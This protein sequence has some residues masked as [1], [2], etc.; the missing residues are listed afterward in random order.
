MKKIIS[1]LVLTA[2]TSF[3]PRLTTA[4]ATTIGWTNGTHTRTKGVSVSGSSMQGMAIR[5][6]ES[7]AQ[8]LKGNSIATV[9]A[10]FCSS[11]YT[12]FTLFITDDLDGEYLYS[13][14]VSS[15]SS[16]KEYTLDTPYEISGEELYIGFVG[17]ISN[18]YSP[19]SFD[20]ST[21]YPE[22]SYVYNNG[23]WEDCYE[24][25]NGV[26]NIQLILSEDISF[27]DASLR[28]T[29]VDGFFRAGESIE[30]PCG[31]VFNFG[32]DTINTIEVSYKVADNE[33]QVT[34]FTDLGL[35]NGQTYD[36][37]LP[38]V[39]F[40]EAGTFDVEV[41][42]S[43]VNGM[44]YD[45]EPTDNSDSTS[46]TM[47][48]QD[49]KRMFLVEN[50]TTQQCTNCP[51]G[52]A[53]LQSAVGDRDDVCVVAHHSGY[54]TDAFTMTE[55]VALLFLEYTSS[56]GTFAPGFMTNRY[57]TD[58][59]SSTYASPGFFT[60]DPDD[61][62]DRLDELADMEPYVEVEIN[63]VY[64]EDT[65][66]LSG[67]VDVT[68]Y[69]TPPGGVVYINLYAVQDSIVASQT[70]GGD[71]YTHRHVFRGSIGTGNFGTP[72]TIAAGDVYSHEFSYT[73]PESITASYSSSYAETF[74]VD[75]SHMSLVAFASNYN[76]SDANDCI[77]YNAD[78]V[79]F[80]DNV[81][82]GITNVD[83]AGTDIDVYVL[84]GMVYADD[85]CTSLAVY[86]LTGKV[87]KSVSGDVSPFSLDS[88]VYIVR[89]GNGKTTATKKLIVK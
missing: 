76:S 67:T 65:R 66:E 23:T 22:T 40:S 8:L 5:L 12:D 27:T 84:D 53:T 61:I 1:L 34:T 33:A 47:Y 58:S 6:P 72:V 75:L 50:F 7:K 77:V 85:T 57:R 4:G 30:I 89:T 51:T 79:A 43:S 41:A 81:T 17:T 42:V 60:S 39:V 69:A 21:G 64:D 15:S 31:E 14:S 68:A 11:R 24:D 9:Y 35:A 36:I 44:E 48:P 2:L 13:Q 54:Y 26:A 10:A 18:S 70:S 25:G 78:E 19:L 87:V 59:Q 62:T 52:H 32:T 3:G 28:F 38:A 74:D 83:A 16:W 20:F 56:G 80:L 49:L 86:D 63:S 55:D 82:T 46:M 71:N 29:E 73:V 45:D 88:G 37:V